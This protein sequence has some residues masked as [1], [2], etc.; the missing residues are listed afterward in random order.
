MIPVE[1]FIGDQ[2][3]RMREG[4][5][6]DIALKPF[7]GGRKVAIIDD[8]DF[9][10]EEGA[11]S[12]LKTLEEPPPRSVLILI[13]T[14][15]DRQLPTI[16][17]RAQMFRFRPL[18][19]KT[20]AEILVARGLASD[21]EAALR[22]A[23]FAEGSV[24][25][26]V[27]LADEDLWSFRRTLLK[28]LAMP[29]LAGV[30][31][32]GSLLPFVEGAGKEAKVRRVRARQVVAFAVDF[33]RQLLRSRCGAVPVGNAE[34]LKA[35]EAAAP[36]WPGDEDTV[37]ACLE[38]SLEALAHLERNAHQPTLLECWLNDLARIMQTGHAVAS[39]GDF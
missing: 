22:L 13:S 18:A 14:S 11:N 4:L 3:H 29:R 31:L 5:C 6:H 33:Y 19:E 1:A 12:L 30:S 28:E 9:L 36:R 17:S 26:A 10:N 23:S 37:T 32:A 35:V 20:V 7:M 15:A 25:Q 38:R 39:Y 16:R 2:A 21:R 27:A 24:E 34:L 8:A